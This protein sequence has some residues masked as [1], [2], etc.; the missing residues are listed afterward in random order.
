MDLVC[1]WERG[2][3]S[4]PPGRPLKPALGASSTREAKHTGILVLTPNQRAIW[5]AGGQ[6]FERSRR[7]SGDRRRQRGGRGPGEATAGWGCLWFLQS[8]SG[9]RV[10]PGGRP[11]PPRRPPSCRAP[12]SSSAPE[13]QGTPAGTTP[14]VCACVQVPAGAVCARPLEVSHP[15]GAQ[16]AGKGG[17]RAA[18]ATGAGEAGESVAGPGLRS[19]GLSFSQKHLN[20]D[21][22]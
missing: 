5:P 16:M 19:R 20:R 9:H 14:T 13:A 10:L 1:Q 22:S 7:A 4:E 12:S 8:A 11:Q 15:R 2:A 6:S 17:V 3:V 21:S 18:G